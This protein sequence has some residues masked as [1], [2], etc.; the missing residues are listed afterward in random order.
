M[1]YA[2]LSLELPDLTTDADS[3][4]AGDVARIPPASAVDEVLE[5]VHA[6]IARGELLLAPR[7]RCARVGTM[8]HARAPVRATEMIMRAS[9]ASEMH[10]A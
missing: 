8:G 9:K 4:R 1:H 3:L 2:F 6:Q 10:R 5:S 7:A